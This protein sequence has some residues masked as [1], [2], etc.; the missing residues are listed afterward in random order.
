MRGHP[1][2]VAIARAAGPIF[3]PTCALE[4]L[5][6]CFPWNERFR[7]YFGQARIMFMQGRRW[8]QSSKL[9]TGQVESA[10]A[11]LRR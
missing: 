3:T 6:Q 8:R 1:H 10:R 5:F 2:R 9:G 7:L 11:R 4:S